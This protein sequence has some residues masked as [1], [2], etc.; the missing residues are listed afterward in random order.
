MRVL[1]MGLPGTG[2]TTL[3]EAVNTRLY[4]RKKVLW[5]NADK[6][7][8]EYDDWDFSEEGRLRQSMRMRTLS[9]KLDADVVLIDMV[10][11]LPIMREHIDPHIL[12]WVDTLKEGRFADTNKIFVPPTEYDIHVTS[13]DSAKWSQVVVDKI[14]SYDRN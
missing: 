11:P 7:R 6:V 8:E 4:F 13:Q 12:V 2:K 5:L 14:L 10:A 1:I 3:A 9:A